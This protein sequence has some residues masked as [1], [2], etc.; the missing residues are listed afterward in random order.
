MRI[1]IHQKYA[2]ILTHSLKVAALRS[3]MEGERDVEL[4]I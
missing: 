1:V 3:L 4:R 2:G